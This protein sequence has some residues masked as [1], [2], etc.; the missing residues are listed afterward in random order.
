[1][2][3]FQLEAGCSPVKRKSS[4][5]RVRP[6][7]DEPTWPSA[8]PAA[9]GGQEENS[10]GGAEGGAQGAENQNGDE[11]GQSCAK[12][13]R[14]KLPPVSSDDDSDDGAGAGGG[15]VVLPTKLDFITVASRDK[16]P[17][18]CPAVGVAVLGGAVTSDVTPTPPVVAV[19]TGAST[20]AT[21]ST[22]AM[23][24]TSSS[25]QNSSGRSHEFRNVMRTMPVVRPAV[26][27]PRSWPMKRPAAPPLQRAPALM[28]R[29]VPHA[30]APSA[31][32]PRLQAFRGGA[33]SFAPMRN[34]APPAATFRA[35]MRWPIREMMPAGRPVMRPGP[36]LGP[37]PGLHPL[38][39]Q[40][41]FMPNMPFTNMFDQRR[42]LLIPPQM[43]LLHRR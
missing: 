10:A 26:I 30:M 31:A 8:R 34:P 20:S 24:S 43:P 23:A 32:P 25:S 42:P 22:S 2:F 40:S 29:P 7:R 39:G 15:D 3:W 16:S 21:A 18:A 6:P 41:I 13:A 17:T 35:P 37:R 33:V 12:K 1:M 5:R 11:D 19:A 28:R 4:R 27:V 38:G 14:I 9:G 36:G